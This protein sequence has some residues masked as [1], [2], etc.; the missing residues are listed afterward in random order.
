MN[1][2]KNRI[3]FFICLLFMVVILWRLFTAPHHPQGKLSYPEFTQA[4]EAGKIQSA[5]IVM[6]YD[7]ADIELQARDSSK[8][9]LDDFPTKDLPTLIRKMMD[10]GVAVEFSKAHRFEP[11]NFVLNIAPIALLAAAVTYLFYIRRKV[12]A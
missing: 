6:G 1:S 4:L 2:L 7:L 8:L 5:T 3:L 12:R 9:F 10:K 11:A